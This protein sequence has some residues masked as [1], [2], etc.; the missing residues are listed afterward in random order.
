MLVSGANRTRSA[1]ASCWSAPRSPLE[2]D[3]PPKPALPF[4]LRPGGAGPRVGSTPRFTPRA[5][6]AVSF[7]GELIPQSPVSRVGA[8]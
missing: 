2:T 7:S 4:L 1:A 8:G 5:G 6:A 3:P